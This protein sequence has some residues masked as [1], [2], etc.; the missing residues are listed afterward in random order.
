MGGG[1][2]ME[3]GGIGEPAGMG[4][5]LGRSTLLLTGASGFVGKAVLSAL[6]M[7][8]ERVRLL[9]L[10][11]AADGEEARRRLVDEVLTAEPFRPI[12]QSLV[13][14][15]LGEGEL[16]ALAGDLR[17]DGLG[18]RSAE[19]LGDVSTVIH[20][21][22]SVSFEEP[23]DRAIEINGLG[24]VRLLD[25]IREAGADPDFVH[26]STAYTADCRVPRVAEDDVHPG[27]ADLDPQAVL[28][29]ALEWRA[30]AEADSGA[31]AAHFRRDAERAVAEGR[32]GSVEERGEKLR[33]RWVEERLA[34][35]GRQ[36]AAAA[37][38]PDTYSMTKAIGERQLLERSDR[39]TVVR[40][41]IVESALSRPWP[42]WLEGFKVADPLIIAYASRGLTHLPGRAS[43][44]IDIVPVD[45]VANACLAA[46][47]FPARG[48]RCVSV[49]SSG[50]N[51]LTLGELAGHTR[52]YF[53]RHPLL[54]RHGREIAIGDLRF[55]SRSRALLWSRGR[56]GLLAIGARVAVAPPARRARP[57]LRRNTSLARRIRRMVEIYAPY[58]QL[59]CRF[60]DSG[61]QALLAELDPEDRADF[62][63]DTGA[64]DWTDYLERIHLPK[65]HQMVAERLPGTARP[66]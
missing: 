18:C 21:A 40:P 30:E 36:F 42:G 14:R 48:N 2:H 5:R 58:T 45:C 7:G 64:I 57:A 19:K 34:E 20:C 65:L 4:A 17:V 53:R 60:D 22:A 44:P 43:N 35:R 10:L 27:L 9:V 12:P 31:R 16:E 37:G 41:S 25:A 59:S 32:A 63:F 26:V 3:G 66:A 28:G 15:M 56:E 54:D 62:S 38:W 49:S 24:A 55:A 33:R 39:V 46:A 52:A 1:L 50:R 8:T 29:A 13:E 11:R 51:P 61:A 6:L 47:A 23:L